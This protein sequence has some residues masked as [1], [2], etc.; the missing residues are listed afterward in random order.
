[1]TEANGHTTVARIL[2]QAVGLQAMPLT[3]TLMSLFLF[4]NKHKSSVEV[5]L[6][7]GYE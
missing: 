6:P 5:L 7:L 3:V 1:M 4:M 2:I